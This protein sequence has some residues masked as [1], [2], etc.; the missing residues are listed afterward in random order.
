MEEKTQKESD[1]QTELES[2][3]DNDSGPSEKQDNKNS[4]LS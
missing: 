1:A 4:E 2:S 3:A